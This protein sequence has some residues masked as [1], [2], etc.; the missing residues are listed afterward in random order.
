[1][2]AGTTAIKVTQTYD[3]NYTGRY[4]AEVH[5][6]TGYKRGNTGFYG[7]AFRV[8]DTWQFSPAQSYNIGQFIAEFQRY[9]V[10][11]L[12]AELDGVAVRRPA[13]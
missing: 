13:V 12:D 4:H 10:R 5:R 3:P 6:G 1:M 7:F 11:R 9:R 2:Y 8:S